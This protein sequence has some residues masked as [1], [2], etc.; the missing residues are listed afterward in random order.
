[1]RRQNYCPCQQAYCSA[2]KRSIIRT[3]TQV[4]PST[5]L[6]PFLASCIRRHRKHESAHSHV[7]PS[8]TPLRKSHLRGFT[9]DEPQNSLSPPSLHFSCA[10]CGSQPP[11]NPFT[12]H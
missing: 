11:P 2:E 3:R 12:P 9:V 8:Q 4:C 1:M 10:A 7:S 5:A 6:A